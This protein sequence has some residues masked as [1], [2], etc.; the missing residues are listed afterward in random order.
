MHARTH[1]HTGPSY[2]ALPPPPVQGDLL[3]REAA[4]EI[5][6]HLYDDAPRDENW[7]S[8]EEVVLL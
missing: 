4:W 5:W 6:V 2:L 3:H 1:P 8:V 7:L